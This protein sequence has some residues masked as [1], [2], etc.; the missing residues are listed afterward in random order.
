[1]AKLTLKDWKSQKEKK[2]NIDKDVSALELEF[3]SINMERNNLKH[4]ISDEW[5]KQ[6]D[7]AKIGN[8]FCKEYKYEREQFEVVGNLAQLEKVVKRNHSAQKPQFF[9]YNKNGNHWVNLCITPYTNGTTLIYKDSLGQPIPQDMKKLFAKKFK[10]IDIKQC[11]IREQ[12]DDYNCGPMSL[13]NLAIMMRALKHLPD[14]MEKLD[15]MQFASTQ[16]VIKFKIKLANSFISKCTVNLPENEEF[17]FKFHSF[18]HNIPYPEITN[19]M[20]NQLQLFSAF[21]KVGKPDIKKEVQYTNYIDS[22]KELI[23]ELKHESANQVLMRNCEAEIAEIRE[24]KEESYKLLLT[25][26]KLLGLE[27]HKWFIN[28]NSIKAIDSKYFENLENYTVKSIIPAFTE[29]FVPIISSTLNSYIPGYKDT[30]NAVI[31]NGTH[32]VSHYIK[33]KVD[34]GL[35]KIGQ[36]LTVQIFDQYGKLSSYLN[37]AQHFPE[38]CE[39]LNLIFDLLPRLQDDEMSKGLSKVGNQ[40]NLQFQEINTLKAILSHHRKG[41]GYQKNSQSLKDKNLINHEKPESTDPPELAIKNLEQKNSE[42]RNLEQITERIIN[43]EKPESTDPSETGIKPLGQ[44][45]KE[46]K[47][48]ENDCAQAISELERDYNI[49]KSFYNN[50]WKVESLE[51]INRWAQ[52]KKGHL[53]EEEVL[54]TI[55]IMDRANELTTGGHHLR[56]T[57][58]LSVLSFLRA[59]EGKGKLCQINTGEGKTTIVSLLAV[60]KSLQGEKVDVITSNP[61]LAEEGIKDKDAFYKAFGLSVATNNPTPEAY[62]NGPKP[63]YNADVLYGSINNFQFDY[64]KDSFLGLGTRGNRGFG[65][66]ILDEVD[67][68]IID[69][70]GH[71]AKLSGP[72][73]GMESFRYIYIKIWQELTKAED[74]EEILQLYKESAP[75]EEDKNIFDSIYNRLKDKVKLQLT[76]EFSDSSQD[77]QPEYNLKQMIPSHLQD[78]AKSKIDKWIEYA[79]KAKYLFEENKQ[80]II[81][82]KDGEEVVIPV[83]YANTGVSLKNT[84]WSHGL[85]QFLQL[86]H[87]LRL[88][89]ESLTSSFVSNL[90][91]INKYVA[92]K[93]NPDDSA[94]K[95][96]KI[97]GLTGTLGSEGE[98]DLLSYIYNVTY[99]IIPTYKQ[100]NFSKLPSVIVE[101][102]ALAQTVSL[103]A[104]EKIDKGRAVLI[105]C[106]TIAD[107]REIEKQLKI[108]QKYEKD[109]LRIKIYENEDNS[110]ITEEKLEPG[111]IVIATN[112]AGR[113]TDFKTSPALKD[114]GGLHVITAFF[115]CNKRVHDQADGRTARQ[116]DPGTA[117]SIIRESEVKKLGLKVENLSDNNYDEDLEK[118]RDKIEKER[119]SNIKKPRVAE[120]NYQDAIFSK[121][122][123]K[124]AALEKANRETEGFYNVLEDL[125]ETWAFWLENHNLEREKIKAKDIYDINEVTNNFQKFE[126]HAKRQIIEG[127][128]C[129][130]PYYSIKQAKLFLTQVDK[131]GKAEDS[132]NNA[133]KLGSDT[134]NLYSACMTLFEL[135]INRGNALLARFKDIMAKVA[136]FG[137]FTE[138]KD[139]N[140]INNARNALL[141]AK[142]C[143]ELE[144]NYINQLLFTDESANVRKFSAD[145]KRIVVPKLKNQENLLVKH[146][147]SRLA[148][149]STYYHNTESLFEQLQEPENNNGV[150]IQK[151][152]TNYFK[153]LSPEENK[154][155]IIDKEVEE[156]KYIGL[157][158]IYSVSKVPDVEPLIIEAAQ[159]QIAAGLTLLAAAAAFPPLLIVNGPA[160]GALISEGVCDIVMELIKFEGEEFNHTEYTKSKLISYGISLGT[161]GIGPLITATK[162]LSK[163]IKLCQKISGAF[164]K[165]PFMKN[166]CSKVASKLNKIEKLPLV[167]IVNNADNLDEILTFSKVIKNIAL[168]TT[169]A[170]ASCIIMDKIIAPCLELSLKELKPKIDKE[171]EEVLREELLEKQVILIK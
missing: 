146:L 92:S 61:V 76:K 107:L 102:D 62:L 16:D 50:K 21:K 139:H 22:N 151:K 171:V 96:M 57:Q 47:V 145:F 115:P 60:I 118:E 14:F 157:D 91:Y 123:E 24:V 98:Q 42:D 82:E 29:S 112:I 69:N 130:N 77:L 53:L 31:A 79:I 155:I 147:I 81:K 124:F 154:E 80:Y 153:E 54:E 117:Q 90:G 100:K 64:L 162:T 105:I 109:V 142:S 74:D 41:I 138:L 55:A 158:S 108:F 128:I 133:I 165:T 73:P 67:N 170:V 143:L 78:Y 110:S 46:I 166:I 23:S 7:I 38:N 160:A 40:L 51:S 34:A 149:L 132:I 144:I 11:T 134:N 1:M 159:G 111:D 89:A 84:I 85:H 56:D 25:K 99:T 122:A 136:V 33:N 114:N 86:K 17:K 9:I 66:V 28:E 30:V 10:I 20:D 120:L 113:G 39:K 94:T 125:K 131:L 161:M 36:K 68:M 26:I 104:L 152:V 164:R 119:L 70:A 3:F 49:V 148:T 167:K 2:E 63:C 35:Q 75:P 103:L 4:L 141:K 58:I 101:D 8:F 13:L 83:D 156:L 168:E 106:E 32:S 95:H 97:F 15:T 88:T 135:S 169:I 5:Y 121:F 126:K 19:F 129:W 137:H 45:L 59:K 71:I 52:R 93:A 6:K 116:G 12:E 72:F 37:I 140:Y 127:K 18:L 65:M 150:I 43:H 44:L 87:N 163:S 27:N 48:I